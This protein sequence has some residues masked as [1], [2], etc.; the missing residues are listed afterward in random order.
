MNS[1]DAPYTEL[2]PQTVLDA[3]WSEVEAHLDGTSGHD[4]RSL[5]VIRVS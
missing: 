1:S 3:I 5:V 4:D 2:S